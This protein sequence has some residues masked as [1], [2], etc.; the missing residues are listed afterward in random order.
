MY[1]KTI[2][3]ITIK[4][5]TVLDQIKSAT[6]KPV[7]LCSYTDINVNKSLDSALQIINEN[8]FKAKGMIAM[9]G[10][11]MSYYKSMWFD[12]DKLTVIIDKWRLIH[13]KL[14][15]QLELKNSSTLIT[16]LND[17]VKHYDCINYNVVQFLT[18]LDRTAKTCCHTLITTNIVSEMKIL[19]DAGKLQSVYDKDVKNVVVNI[20][21]RKLIKQY[22]S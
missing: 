6:H 16:A 21:N 12:L 3:D 8:S 2:A 4:P 19:K 5:D 10:Y 13:N 20:L 22:E 18:M 11:L 14:I 1:M 9:P 17:A 15:M 7:V